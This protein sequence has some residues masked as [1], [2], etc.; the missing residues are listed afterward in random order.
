MVNQL[1]L[2]GM[3]NFANNISEEAPFGVFLKGEKTTYRSLR[4][5][6]NSAQASWRSWSE[7]P[8]SLED[9]EKGASN[10]AAWA[11]LAELCEA[12]LTDTSKDLEVLSWYVASQIHVANPL[13]KCRDALLLMEGLVASSIDTLHPIPPVEKL[14]GETDEARASEIAELKLRPFVQLFGEVEGTGLLNGPITNLPL[15]GEVTFG[16]YILA[17]KDGTVSAL[18]AEVG[19]HISAE[20]DALTLKIEALQQMARSI[21]ALETNIK[22]YAQSHGQVPPL[23]GYGARL[24]N[25]VLAAILTLVEGL[26]F[27]WPG[28]GANEEDAPAEQ[29]ESDGE[30]VVDQAVQSGGGGGG[31]G[32]N[33]NA[34]VSNRHD[35]L[36]AI[37]QLA[38]YFRKSEPHS[39]IC[40][41]LDRAVRWGNLNAAELYREILSDGSVGMSQMALMTGLESQG[42]AD[43]FGRKGAGAAGGVEHPVLDN[44]AAAIPKPETP[45]ASNKQLQQPVITQPEVANVQANVPSS[46]S[47]ASA[48]ASEQIDTP[49]EN[50]PV[51]DF[52][53]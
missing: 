22:I 39:P 46:E 47:V 12:C 50:L 31:A 40:L 6:F 38:K 2:R 37:A 18:A 33:P 9:R 3:S 32:F 41:L 26:G 20:S 45:I 10:T 29:T 4:T 27:P 1:G 23:I 24:M 43:N 42:F 7:T 48:D 49:P 15:I 13:E 14:K 51:E 19:T 53:W 16:K 25:D 17:N 28:E 34:T 8:E 5:S 44:Y 52:E 36:V 30:T 21:V 35:A 11:A